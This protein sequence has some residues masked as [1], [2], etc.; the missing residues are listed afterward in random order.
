MAFLRS[1]DATPSDYDPPPLCFVTEVTGIMSLLSPKINLDAPR[2]D[3]ST[4][5]GRA[6]HFFITT[7]PLNLLTTP[8]QLA[9]AKAKVDAY[10]RGELTDISEDE[11]WS[12]KHVVDSAYHPETGTVLH[13]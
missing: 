13:K 12:L 7:N 6:K 11:I 1:L 5:W 3:Q 8:S 4:Y 9:E 2:Y 10:K